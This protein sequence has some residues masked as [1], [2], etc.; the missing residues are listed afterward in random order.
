MAQPLVQAT[1]GVGRWDPAQ[2][3]LGVS[4]AD[5][6]KQRVSDLTLTKPDPTRSLN[7]MAFTDGEPDANV[8]H[9]CF[10]LPGC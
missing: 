7:A 9:F 8:S 3:E 4:I 10:A 1:Y 6:I 5:Q 2:V